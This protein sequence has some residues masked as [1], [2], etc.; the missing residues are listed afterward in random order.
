MSILFQAMQKV[1]KDYD[2]NRTGAGM[3]YGRVKSVEPLAVEIDAK[4]TLT[5]KFLVVAQHLTD[6][7]I[8]YE[9]L[10]EGRATHKEKL[11]TELTE[12]QAVGGLYVEHDGKH[13]VQPDP[14]GE[15][16]DFDGQGTVKL[17]NHLMVDDKVILLRLEGGHQ[18]IVMD[19][20]PE[21]EKGGELP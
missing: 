21:E 9:I 2:L 14:P 3:L 1:A 18:Y 4:L 8:P 16:R 20:V 13:Y 11:P 19:R 6:Y 17:L 15:I 7:E 10:S 12:I 5:E